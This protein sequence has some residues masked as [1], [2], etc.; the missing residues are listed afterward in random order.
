MNVGP[1]GL[2]FVHGSKDRPS[3]ALPYGL[4]PEDANPT[5]GECPAPL[6]PGAMKVFGAAKPPSEDQGFYPLNGR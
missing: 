1:V 6:T 2:F 4:C 3:T 5:L